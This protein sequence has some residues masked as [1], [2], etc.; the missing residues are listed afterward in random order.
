MISESSSLNRSVNSPARGG[1]AL[2]I[3]QV[4]RNRSADAVPAQVEEQEADSC[5]SD[6]DPENDDE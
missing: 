5:S 1:S 2:F 6:G 3:P 4:A